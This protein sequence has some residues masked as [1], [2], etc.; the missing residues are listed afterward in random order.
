MLNVRI[1]GPEQRR[2]LKLSGLTIIIDALHWAKFQVEIRKLIFQVNPRDA[3]VLC[4][5]MPQ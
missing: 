5:K 4:C 3:T 2:N 1:L